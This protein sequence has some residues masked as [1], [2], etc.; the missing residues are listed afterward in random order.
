M[1]NI[2]SSLPSK[3][4]WITNLRVFATLTVILL[5]AAGNGLFAF[6]KLPLAQ[7]WICNLLNTFGR[8]AVPIFVMLSGYLLLP[9]YKELGLFLNKR[10][11]RIC[12]PFLVWTIIYMVW[13][14]YFG[15][16]TEKTPLV[17][18]VILSKILLGGGGGSTHLWFVYMLLGIYA[19][20]PILSRWVMNAQGKE[21]QYFL[22]IWLIINGILPILKHFWG[23]STN[24]ELRYFMGFIGYFVLGHYLASLQININKWLWFVLFVLAWLLAC[25]A[26][27]QL[28][29]S[30]N[31]FDNSLSDYLS[32]S[33]MAMSASIFLGF[34]AVLNIEFWPKL[35]AELDAC[36]YGMYLVHIL[37]LKTL[38]RQFHLNHTFY[39][40]F[41]GIVLH[42]L[43]CA[44]LSFCIV[45]LLRKL[46]KSHWL[47]G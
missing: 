32:L 25:W 19:V 35:M 29:W 3:I 38:S 7:W 46:P 34:K 47:L 21:V 36:S 30:Q 28:S 43:A 33:V 24:L 14:S 18:S 44:F 45:Y 5:H 1:D 26:V 23:I 11:L 16:R 17:F 41:V 13:G 12:I 6:H 4:A 9:K 15:I 37:I 27:Y 40:P 42:F 10:L 2:S 20:T 31:K 8:F 22:L 39:H